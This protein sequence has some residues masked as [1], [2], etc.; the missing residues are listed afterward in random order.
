MRAQ[1]QERKTH[2]CEINNTPEHA[3][4]RI[5]I[6]INVFGSM[7]NPQEMWM[8]FTTMYADV[9]RTI[10]NVNT[11]K[12]SRDPLHVIMDWG[13]FRR[14]STSRSGPWRWRYVDDCCCHLVRALAS[15][16]CSSSVPG[17]C[18]IRS[19]GRILS[20]S[21]PCVSPFDSSPYPP[22]AV[23]R[24]PVTHTSSTRHRQRDDFSVNVATRNSL[25]YAA[26]YDD[27]SSARKQRTCNI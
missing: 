17:W 6:N 11:H 19:L 14:I 4:P 23:C 13:E 9:T 25:N 5:W 15:F 12:L 3:I 18:S 22:A 21:G 27:C 24:R 10:T 20:V 1:Q 16:P 2:A 8:H 7:V 26:Q